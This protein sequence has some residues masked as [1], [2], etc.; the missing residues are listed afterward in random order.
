MEQIQQKHREQQNEKLPL[1]LASAS[2]RRRELIS[3]LGLPYITC[4][5]PVEEE[6][7][8]ARY[9]GPADGL[10]QWLAEQ[11]ALATHT[12]PGFDGHIVV[13]ADT[14]VILDDKILGK[15]RDEEEARE[16]LVALRGRRH[17]V[18]TGVAASKVEN[19][20]LKVQSERVVTP[21][22]MRNYSEKEI[23][24]YVASGEPMDK[25]G[26][27][28]IQNLSFHPVERIDGCYLNVVGLP[29]CA[30][31]DVLAEFNVYPVL[32][33]HESPCPWS[34]RCKV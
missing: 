34:P 7:L 1:V 3:L 8:E 4:V 30:L 14:T 11:K 25:A 12:L 15:P 10:A 29:L 9:I 6:M 18:V 33:P 26:A 5:S 24:A 20:I 2:P 28:G 21:V 13:T 17:Y 19:D 27:Y 22:T 31:V 16:I 23:A 32:H